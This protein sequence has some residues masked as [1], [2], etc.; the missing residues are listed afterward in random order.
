MPAYI[1]NPFIG[2]NAPAPKLVIMRPERGPRRVSPWREAHA[3]KKVRALRGRKRE[4]L[5]AF[6]AA[7]SCPHRLLLLSA[8]FQTN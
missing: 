5:F 6:V 4:L 7:A 1:A 2:H 3:K 8:D